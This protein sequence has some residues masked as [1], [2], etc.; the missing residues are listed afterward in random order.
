LLLI[1]NTNSTDSAT[2]LNYYLQ[3]RPMISGANVLGFGCPGFYITNYPANGGRVGVTNIT[4]YETVS[5]SDFTNQVL[6]PILNWLA[7][8]PTKRP[9]YVVLMLDVPS[10]IYGTATN[11]ANFPFYPS[12]NLIPSVSV[13]IATSVSGWQP[14]ITHIN[15]NG[16]NDCIGYINK[17]SRFGTN[18]YSPINLSVSAS[19]NGYGNTNWYFD[20]TAYIGI[21]GNVS[22]LNASNGVVQAGASPWSI[23]YTNVTPDNSYSNHICSAFNMAGYLCFGSHSSLGIEFPE[24]LA[25]SGNSGWWLIETVESFNGRRYEADQSTIITWFEGNSFGGIN[26]SNTP[27]GAV[28]NTD[29]PDE[30]GHNNAAIYFG[31]W[32]AR[33]NFAI[34]AWASRLTPEFQAVGDPFVQK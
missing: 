16:T 12:G 33:K 3:N 17:L 31:L 34:C 18:N 29:E 9:Q 26:Y 24:T 11:A 7:A 13:E 27:V 10:R 30:A 14:F 32:A 21:T 2:V 5:P 19:A 23:T 4:D 22:G 25:W 8:N 15:M 6:N 28:S 20:N 1:Y